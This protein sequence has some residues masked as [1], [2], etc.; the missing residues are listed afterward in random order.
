MNLFL[1]LNV[2]KLKIKKTILKFIIFILILKK[3]MKII[4]LIIIISIK[5]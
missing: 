4:F 3:N 2:F 1:F 5:I